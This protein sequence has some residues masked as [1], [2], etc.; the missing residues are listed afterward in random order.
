MLNFKNCFAYAVSFVF[1]IVCAVCGKTLHPLSKERIC[2]DCKE[3]LPKINDV[4]CQICG[5]PLEGAE[6]FC[7]VCGKSRH[8]FSFNKMRSV[9]MY[10]NEMRSLVL[11]IK[12]SNKVFLANDFIDDMADVFRK[13]SFFNETDFIVPVPLNVIRHF[14]RGYN[15]AEFLAQGLAKAINKPLLTKVLVRKKIT[16]PQ[17]KLSKKER[18]ENIKNSFY[19]LSSPQIKNKTIL[20]IDDI[21]TTGVTVSTCAYELKKAGAKKV[22]VLTLTRD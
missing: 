4:V 17:F 5:T 18:E 3:K 8:L 7:N 21:V 1:P 16:K 20:L 10:K 11:K 19:A 12:Y 14:K 22:Y 6:K 9:Y 13:N 2:K 15:Q